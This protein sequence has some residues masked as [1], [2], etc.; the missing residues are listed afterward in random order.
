MSHARRKKTPAHSMMLW[1]SCAEESSDAAMSNVA[2]EVGLAIMASY[3]MDF[4]DCVNLGD[5][6]LV[7]TDPNYR[8][9]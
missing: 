2:V 8:T 1:I 4:F 6:K 9:C 7:G 5:I 3:T